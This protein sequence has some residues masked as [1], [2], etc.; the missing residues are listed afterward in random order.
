MTN[1]VNHRYASLLELQH[2]RTGDSSRRFG[3]L[4]RIS[5]KARALLWVSS[6]AIDS[7]EAG[8]P[9]AYPSTPCLVLQSVFHD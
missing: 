4:L 3:K 6:P 5:G 8:S 1:S 9:Y 7:D 2:E